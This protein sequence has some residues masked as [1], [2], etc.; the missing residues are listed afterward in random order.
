MLFSAMNSFQMK[1]LK[2]PYTTILQGVVYFILMFFLIIATSGFVLALAPAYYSPGEPI[3]IW[4]FLLLFLIV[5][6]VFFLLLRKVRSRAFFEGFLTFAIFAGIWFLADI[7]LPLGWGVFAAAVIT[8]SKFVYPK[9]WWQNLIMVF[10]I[11]GIA[12][13]LGLSLP[14]VTALVILVILSF[15]DII[16]VYK[17]GHM[18]KMFK[19]L[20]ERGVVFALVIPSHLKY[21]V[22]PVKGVKPQENFML[23]GTGDLALPGLFVASL[24]RESVWQAL[25]AAIGSLLGFALMDIIFINQAKRRPMPALPPIAAGAVVGF[26]IAIIFKI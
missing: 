23:L 9:I 17:T 5:T 8:L 2:M 19:E 11:A 16:A 6:F 22:Q 3:S 10:G 1:K 15:Y 7:W 20:V 21:I 12:A 24:V 26:L 14:W 13:S 18:V 4:Y 25:A